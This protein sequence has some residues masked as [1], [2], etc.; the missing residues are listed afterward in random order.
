MTEHRAVAV[1]EEAKSSR[2]DADRI[3]SS[4]AILIFVFWRGKDVVYVVG[5]GA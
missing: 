4:S 2:N 3:G 5:K 1:E